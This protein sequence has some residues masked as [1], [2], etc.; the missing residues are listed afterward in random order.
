MNKKTLTN[1]HSQ[2]NK[3]TQT[4]AKKHQQRLDDMTATALRYVDHQDKVSNKLNQKAQQLTD[5]HQIRLD[6]ISTAALQYS[7]SKEIQKP[8]IIQRI[9]NTITHPFLTPPATVTTAF[10]SL[11]LLGIATLFWLNAPLQNN[12]NFERMQANTIASTSPT[13]VKDTDIPLELLE[14]MDFYVWLSQSKYAHNNS[15][16]TQIFLVAAWHNQRGSRQ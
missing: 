1:P 10:F 5:K 13:W 14:N 2:L 4:L 9:F 3:T 8:S 15:P 6:A 11:C 16:Q 7:L 12:I